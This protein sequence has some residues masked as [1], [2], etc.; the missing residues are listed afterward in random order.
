MQLWKPRPERSSPLDA[1][2]CLGTDK[3]DLR[4]AREIAAYKG[5][6]SARIP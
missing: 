6:Y 3:L 4:K 1:F 2:P 5:K